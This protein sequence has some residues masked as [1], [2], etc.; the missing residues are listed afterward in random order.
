MLENKERIEIS[1]EILHRFKAG[2]TKLR[3]R[4]TTFIGVYD[5]GVRNDNE[6]VSFGEGPNQLWWPEDKI[7]DFLRIIFIMHYLYMQ[8]KYYGTLDA[9]GY[10]VYG[11][12][13]G[14]YH[15]TKT[16]LREKDLIEAINRDIAAIQDT[17]ID[18]KLGMLF[19]HDVDRI[20]P[21]GDMPLPSTV[22]VNTGSVAYMS[23]YLYITRMYLTGSIKDHP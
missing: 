20:A 5:R 10:G 3:L 8:P 21:D 2:T 18:L 7:E 19:N 23:L 1:E 4:L 15:P 11:F 22:P 14:K 9:D 6:L 12:E 17:T 13:C 16:S